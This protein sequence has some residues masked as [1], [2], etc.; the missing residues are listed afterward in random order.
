MILL[1]WITSSSTVG[2]NFP[3]HDAC[4][5]PPQATYFKAKHAT[6]HTI[7]TKHTI[8]KAWLPVHQGGNE[9]H[10][11][12]SFRLIGPVHHSRVHINHL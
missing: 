5:V 10:I 7:S 6:K 4:S 9:E 3:V 1:H 8:P 2:L 11:A 12:T